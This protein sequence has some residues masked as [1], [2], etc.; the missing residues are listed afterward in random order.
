MAF[1]KERE[2]DRYRETHR[3]IKRRVCEKDSNS[4][5]KPGVISLS[6]CKH[7]IRCLVFYFSHVMLGT[8]THSEIS[9]EQSPKIAAYST[10]YVLTGSVFSY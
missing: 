2:R 5:S 4:V 3:K 8:S 7:F 9:F 10:S 6:N 1:E